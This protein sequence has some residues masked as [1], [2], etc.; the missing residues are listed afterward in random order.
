[1]GVKGNCTVIVASEP[2]PNIIPYCSFDENAVDP[3]MLKYCKSAIANPFNTCVLP[4]AYT[5][6][7]VLIVKSILVVVKPPEL[8]SKELVEP[9]VFK[10]L[11]VPLPEG[12]SIANEAFESTI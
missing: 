5:L 10:I 11:K 9:P 3:G 8:R 12:D 7:P 4:L 1:M 6:W 2:V